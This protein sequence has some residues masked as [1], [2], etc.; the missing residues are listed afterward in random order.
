MRTPITAGKR[1][2][3]AL[4][5]ALE[6]GM[7]WTEAEEAT[8]GLIESAADRVAIL[9]RLFDTEV[10]KPEVSTRRVTELSAEIRQHE[11]NIQKWVSVLDPYM[12]RQPK[13]KQHQ[14]AAHSRWH[15][16]AA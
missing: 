7:E 3:N 2:I 1:L 14:S 15:G 9:K 10:E 6:A 4:S 13:S 8:L 16:G 11:A 5:E 12:S